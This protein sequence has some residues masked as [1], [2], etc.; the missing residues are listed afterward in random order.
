MRGPGTVRGLSYFQ[1]VPLA[2]PNTEYRVGALAVIVAEESFE[3]VSK[4]VKAIDERLFVEKQLDFTDRE[5][6]CIV[7]DTGEQHGAERFVTVYEWRDRK[8]DP[9]PYLSQGIVDEMQRRAQDGTGNILAARAIAERRNQDRLE[10]GRAET[11]AAYFEIGKDFHEHRRVGNFTFVPRSKQLQQTRDRVRRERAE[12][13]E[14]VD[15]ARRIYR[16]MASRQLRE[17]MR[18]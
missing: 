9:I 10:R 2:Q 17:A 7:E 13:L 6:W 15:R 16:A 11:D 4:Q 5:V 14:M 1:V 12:Q 3:W 18:G 8:G